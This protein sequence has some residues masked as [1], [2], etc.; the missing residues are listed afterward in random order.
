LPTVNTTPVESLNTK[1]LKRRPAPI[2]DV[3]PFKKH[4]TTDRQKL[5]SQ[6]N[7]LKKRNMELIHKR[8]ESE[9]KIKKLTSPQESL[10]LKTV[11]EKWRTACQE[12][13]QA[14]QGK[15]AGVTA[16]QIIHAFNLDETQLRYDKE[17]DTFC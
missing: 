9:T 16:G 15:Q 8:A 10:R 4:K 7:N 1:Q 5:E 13:I 2:T 6:I 11:T 17:N 3:R 12:A 14:L